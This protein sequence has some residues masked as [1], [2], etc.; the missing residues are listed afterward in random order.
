MFTKSQAERS[1]RRTVQIC[2]RLQTQARLSHPDLAGLARLVQ[3]DEQLA[4]NLLG[5]VNSTVRGLLH[6]V[7][8]VDHAI[9]LL[10][11]TGVARF[12]EEEMSR[13]SRRP[14]MI[15]TDRAEDVSP[16]RQRT[17]KSPARRRGRTMAGPS[18]QE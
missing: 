2:M 15:R 1:F 6:S 13:L 18:R 9:A 17:A 7:R 8:S 11:A 14:I 5:R 10:G 4:S 16:T 12:A 3:R